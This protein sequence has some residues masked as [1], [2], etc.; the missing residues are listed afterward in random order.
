[1][2]EKFILWF[3]EVGMEDVPRV[4]GKS[5]SLGEMTQ[6]GVPVPFGFT[7]TAAAYRF[8]IEHSQ[9]GSILTESL[10]Q[11][12]DAEDTETL[13]NVGKSIREVIE[14]AEMPEKLERL[15]RISLRNIR[16][17]EDLVSR[18]WLSAPLLLQKIC[19]ML[20]LRD[21]RKPI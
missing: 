2:S 6:A 21:S 11:L 17:K 10:N 9:L 15:I 19:L 14:K 16:K 12:K 13:Q 18:T 5:A 8:F 3:D 20:P 7:T 1:M 4:G